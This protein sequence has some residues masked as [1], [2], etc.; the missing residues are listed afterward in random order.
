MLQTEYKI[1]IKKGV[2]NLQPCFGLP[3]NPDKRDEKCS[4]DREMAI[5][6]STKLISKIFPG[7]IETDNGPAIEETCIYSVSNYHFCFIL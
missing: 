4:R 6:R 7:A 3:I 1:R 5:E 2:H